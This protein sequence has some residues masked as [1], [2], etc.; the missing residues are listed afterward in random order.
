MQRLPDDDFVWAGMSRWFVPGGG[1]FGRLLG[2]VVAMN[3]GDVIRE[4]CSWP[5]GQSFDH[6][7]ASSCK[8]SWRKGD[9]ASATAPGDSV[10]APATV[11]PSPAAP[12]VP[13]SRAA[14]ASQDSTLANLN[15]A[16]LVVGGFGEDEVKAYAPSARTPPD[17]PRR[18]GPNP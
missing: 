1:G 8:L 2:E 11:V 12:S 3:G 6:D 17:S 18:L 5:P 7:D 16:V 10:A 9:D 15:V 4:Q 14:S 13:V